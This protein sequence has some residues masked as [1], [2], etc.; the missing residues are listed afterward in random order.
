MARR[1]V[2]E[3]GIFTGGSSGSAVAGL[4]KS[5]LAANLSPDQ[6]V[7]VLLPDTGSRYLSKLYDDNWM[8]E[9]GFLPSA[10][11]AASVGDVLQTNS[12]RALLTARSSDP[13]TEVVARLRAHDISQLPVVDDS[14]RL[15]GI[16]TEMDLLEHLLHAD[17]IHDPAE[18]IAAMVNPN[19]ITLPR[20]AS[21]NAALDALEHGKVVAV[22]EEGSPVGILTKIDL[23]DFLTRQMTV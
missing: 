3:E 7:V 17:H 13:L 21:L 18:T 23:I 22:A 14:G 2:R 1:L 10:R 11:D 9:N 8:R 15:I 19:V 20:R 4:L 16:V 5:K 12:S 6:H